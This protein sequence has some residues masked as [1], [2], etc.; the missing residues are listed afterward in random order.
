MQAL[1]FF[2]A[3][4]RALC[5]VVQD[6]AKKTNETNV[7]KLGLKSKAYAENSALSI[8]FSRS[9]LHHSSVGEIKE[10]AVRNPD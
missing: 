8:K 7:F 9:L 6:Y 5:E 2:L 10:Q 1:Q 3:L 4:W